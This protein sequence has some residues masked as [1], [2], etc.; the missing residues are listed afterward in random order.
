MKLVRSLIAAALT[1]G[2]SAVALAADP[3]P[4]PQA[5]TT[6]SGTPST[7]PGVLAPNAGLADIQENQAERDAIERGELKLV[8][9]EGTVAEPAVDAARVARRAAFDAVVNEQEARV[10]ALADRLATTTGDDAL[11][12]QRQIETEKLATGRRLLEL[13]LQ[14]ATQDGD[15]ARVERI[16]AAIT[17]WDAPKPTGTPMERTLP[18]NPNR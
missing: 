12:L 8:V 16:Q 10:K 6:Q 14:F 9:P 11:T 13:Q 2:V 18:T 7:A 5:S 3:Q 15:Q 17:D 4:A 1:V